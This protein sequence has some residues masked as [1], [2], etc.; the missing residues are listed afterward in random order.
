MPPIAVEVVELLA[1]RVTLLRFLREEPRLKRDL[2]DE[3]S[4]SRSTV[5]RAVRNL[6]AHDFVARGESVSLTLEGRLA[7]E[8]FERFTE[9]VES[10][11][12]A[13]PVFEP[14]S[15]DTRIDTALVQSANVVRSDS[16]SPQRPFVS[17]QELL[18]EATAVQGFS[19][20][21]LEENVRLFHDRI[22]EDGVSVDLTVAPDVLDE[23]VSTH[24]DPVE[25]A[26][27]TGRLTLRRADP[28]VEYALMLVEQPER[29][30]VCAL[31]YGDRGLAGALHNDDPEAVRWA[32]RVLD[33]VQ[34]DAETVSL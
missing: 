33:G 1:R 14:L 8:A 3:L 18:E 20:A 34:A 25:A 5:D 15:A 30:V 2:A 28:T 7:L 26:L 6:E 31:V 4:V 22:V 32:R 29:T 10:L 11:D 12:D 21:V 24:S 19:P 9:T 16:V 13:A 23:L 17:Y 27:D